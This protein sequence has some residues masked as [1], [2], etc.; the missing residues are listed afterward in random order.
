MWAEV[1]KHSHSSLT[2][3]NCRSHILCKSL[4]NPFTT[5]IIRPFDKPSLPSCFSPSDE[6]WNPLQK[7]VSNGAVLCVS[8]QKMAVD[9]QSS[10]PCSKTVLASYGCKEKCHFQFSFWICSRDDFVV[11][12]ISYMYVYNAILF[13]LPSTLFISFHLSTPPFSYKS[14]FQILFFCCLV[15]HWFYLRLW[16]HGFSTVFWNLDSNSDCSPKSIVAIVQQGEIGSHEPFASQW[17]LL[18]SSSLLEVL[19]M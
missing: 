4:S 12:T 5:S 17:L 7:V 10:V 6:T 14:F 16:D 19:S 15:I 3:S 13:P 11:G 2:T 18:D 8:V 1:V 9:P